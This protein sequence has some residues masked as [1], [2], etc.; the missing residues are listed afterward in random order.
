[1]GSTLG[2]GLDGRIRVSVMATGI[3]VEQDSYA[4]TRAV[5]STTTAV[6]PSVRA[7]PAAPSVAEPEK[8][9]ATVSPIKPTVAIPVQVQPVP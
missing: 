2:E 1:V 5:S 8:P 9:L 3:D 6:R 4:K 7:V